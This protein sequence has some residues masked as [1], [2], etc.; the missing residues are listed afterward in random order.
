MSAAQGISRFAANKMITAQNY[1]AG[2][3]PAVDP[4]LRN[5]TFTQTDLSIMKNFYVHSEK[6]YLQI[7]AEGQN[8]FNIRGY[9]TYNNTLG[10]AFFGEIT[11]A[12]NTPRQIQMSARFIF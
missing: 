10:N 8:A 9:G 3:L 12:G 11:N 4:S 1:V 6:R 2:N 7:R 5:P